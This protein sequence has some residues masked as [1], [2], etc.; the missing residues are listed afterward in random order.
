MIA[1]GTLNGMMLGYQKPLTFAY[2]T[3][4]V[5][6]TSGTSQTFSIP[7]YGGIAPS[8]TRLV[9]AHIFMRIGGTINSATINGVSATIASQRTGGGGPTAFIY[10]VVPSGSSSF[11]IVVNCSSSSQGAGCIVWCMDGL[12]SN[13]PY[14]DTSAAASSVGGTMQVGGVVIAGARCQ[15]GSGAV[16]FS[17]ISGI[18]AQDYQGLVFGD[19]THGGKGAKFTGS[20]GAATLSVSWSPTNPACSLIA[21]I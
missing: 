9:V 11:N 1:P 6:G 15:G 2:V 20:A 21:F 13:T 14:I 17:G 8:A 18:S 12:V 16:S 3:G 7:N 19:C 4:V 10:A 5:N